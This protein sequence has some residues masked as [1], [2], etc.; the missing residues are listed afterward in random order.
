MQRHL[1]AFYKVAKQRDNALLNSVKYQFSEA[2]QKS[3]Y[4]KSLSKLVLLIAR[5]VDFGRKASKTVLSLKEETILNILKNVYQ[6]SVLKGKQS[7]KVT[8]T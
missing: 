8:F 5:D 3:F 7:Q 1:L 4:S 6:S 2:V